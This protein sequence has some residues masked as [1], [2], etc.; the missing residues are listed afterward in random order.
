M[1]PNPMDLRGMAGGSVPCKT[2]CDELNRVKRK[3]AETEA[4]LRD[5]DAKLSILLENIPGGV[6][7]YFGDTGKFDYVSTGVLDIFHCT[8]E[9]FRDHFYNCFFLMIAKVDRDRT[10]EHITDQLSFFDTAEVTYRA[11]DLLGNMMWIYHRSRIMRDESGREKFFV[12]ISDVTE[13]KLVQ[14]QMNQANAMLRAQVER[15]PMT[16]LL[17]KVSMEASIRE[18]LTSSNEEN[19][20][21]MLM[22]DT[23]NFKS[24]NDTFGHQY[25][26]DI[27]KF[28]ANSIRKIFRGSDL[29]AR[30]GGDEF[31]V[32]MKFTT[33]SITRERAK[34]LNDAIRQTLTTEA[35]TVRISCSIGISFF[36]KDGTDYDSLYSAADEA[37]YEAKQKGKD[38]FV[39]R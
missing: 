20:H 9:D 29:V 10:R 31:M 38:C 5:S 12:V 24:V 17:N 14:N 32:F 7:S 34:Q 21:A 36:G 8:E 19:C 1:T 26:D 33:P 16:E 3:L 22:I 28:V 4:L 13:E 30:M 35:G 6:F 25:G 39:I 37:M 15:D 27:I 18:C 11:E 2:P 23:D